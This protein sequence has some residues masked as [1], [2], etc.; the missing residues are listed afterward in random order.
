MTAIE[1]NEG[2]YWKGDSHG[3][4][5]VVIYDASGNVLTSLGGRYTAEVNGTPVVTAS[6][7]YSAGNCVGGKLTL[8]NAVRVAGGTAALQSLLL[9]DAANQKA[10]LELL[11]FNADPTASILNDKAA[12]VIHAND[13]AKIVRRI[14]IAT[15]DYVTIDSKAIVDLAIAGRVLKAASGTSLYAALVTSGTPTYAATTDLTLRLGMLQD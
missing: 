4:G 5:G 1:F 7:A 3:H 14:S 9:I 13:I 12:A 6:S 8:A 10:A 11:L 15:A 2:N